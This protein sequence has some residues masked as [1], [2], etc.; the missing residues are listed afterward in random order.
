M[1]PLRRDKKSN[2]VLVMESQTILMRGVD[3]G[4]FKDAGYQ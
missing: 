4:G 2:N 1:V 3:D